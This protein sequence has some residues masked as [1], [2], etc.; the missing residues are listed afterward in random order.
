MHTLVVRLMDNS[1]Y[2]NIDWFFKSL[3]PIKL[4]YEDP[5]VSFLISEADG[6]T[7]L[8]SSRLTFSPLA[9]Q[10]PDQTVNAGIFFWISG[11]TKEPR[12]T[13]KRIHPTTA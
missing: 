9:T 3:E 8:V 7:S 4:A 13:T 10:I 5:E 2:A 6:K 1:T 11:T 12:L